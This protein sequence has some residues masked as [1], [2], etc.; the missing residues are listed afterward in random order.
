[1]QNVNPFEETF[2][3]ATELVKTGTL[4]VPL[5]PEDDTL[6]TPH[7]FPHIPEENISLYSSKKHDKVV[8]N[9]AANTESSLKVLSNSEKTEI[10]LALNANH[11]IPDHIYALTPIDNQ[12]E[13]PTIIISDSPEPNPVYPPKKD[14]AN[15][16]TKTVDSI[17]TDKTISK[18]KYRKYAGS[19]NVKTNPI[20][21]ND[22]KS[23]LQ[24]LLLKSKKQIQPIE[25]Q[26]ISTNA[27]V[28]VLQSVPVVNSSVSLLQTVTK[29]PI[30]PKFKSSVYA[31]TN[32]KLAENTR[33]D[34]KSIK[35]VKKSSKSR[36]SH[37][38]VDTSKK[39]DMLARNRAAALRC[40]E[41][42]KVFIDSLE[43][44]LDVVNREKQ[45]LVKENSDLKREVLHLKTLLLAHKDCPITKAMNMG[46]FY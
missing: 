33:P 13:P 6:H 7:I 22:T 44:Q 2:R 36:R 20:K 38:D 4:P 42:K 15:S 40:R 43:Q 5:L 39:Q 45:V 46:A 35:T 14:S 30:L 28:I 37:V 24:E 27:P 18:A 17:K 9:A 19:I 12:K 41:R 10:I 16:V 8:L 29:V 21:Q 31:N 3:K 11:G 25:N 26:A 34:L 23:K 1:M 32:D